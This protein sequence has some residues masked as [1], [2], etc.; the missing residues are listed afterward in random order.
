MG[1]SRAAD[2]A[3]GGWR[4]R[5][6]SHVRLGTAFYPDRIERASPERR[7]QLRARGH[8]RRPESA[9]TRP[10][11]L[12]QPGCIHGAA[13]PLPERHLIANS[14]RGPNL[15][16]SDLSLAK[17][18]WPM[19]G[20]QLEFRWEVFNAF[21]HVNLGCRTAQW[22][23]PARAR[24]LTRRRPCARCSSDC[25]SYSE[26]SWANTFSFCSLRGLGPW[27]V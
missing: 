7:L 4:I 5:R 15:Y 26:S 10:Q 12:V 20:K 19:E 25:I 17:N 13:G 24:S 11:P 1:G 22:T 18:F 21:N 14:L 27:P 3:F 23:C 16:N 2:L 6:H 9:D 8:H